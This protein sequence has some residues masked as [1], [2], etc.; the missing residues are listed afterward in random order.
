[1]LIFQPN[2]EFLCKQQKI[3]NFI[4]LIF[5]FFRFF[6]KNNYKLDDLQNAAFLTE[7]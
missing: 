4:K 5:L 1:M 2:F 3:V 7:Y 6:V